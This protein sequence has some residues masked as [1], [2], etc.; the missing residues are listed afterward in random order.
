MQNLI[1][2]DLELLL[3]VLP[4]HLVS[5][6]VNHPQYDELIE[7]IMDLGRPPEARFPEGEVILSERLITNED[8]TYVTDRVGEFGDDNRAGIECTLHRISAIRNRRGTIIGLTCRVGRAVF[9]SVELIRD[10]IEL[11][12]S[13]LIL[14]RPG[15][16]KTTMLRDIARVLADDMDKRVVVVDTS[17]EI[18]GDGDI[19][20]PGIG[21][22]RRMQVAHTAEQHAVMIEAVE[23]HMPQVIV[24]DEIGTELEAQAARTIAERGVQLVGTAHGNTL[25]NLLLN[26]T[27][28]DL[29]GGIGS[30]TL[31]D[32]EARRRGTQKTVLERKSPPTFDV[33]VEQQER[34][35]ILIHL[36]V[37]GTV[38]ALLRGESPTAE[39]RV[40]E[41]TQ[42]RRATCVFDSQRPEL[43][44]RVQSS[45][46]FGS[47]DRRER[48][49]PTPLSAKR[50][51][52]HITTINASSSSPAPSAK[53]VPL[54]SGSSNATALV[55]VE[56]P[57]AI[58]QPRNV[59]GI[60][61]V[62][63]AGLDQS[64]V[65]DVAE[66]FGVKVAFVSS[67]IEADV[68]M[69]HRSRYPRHS[70]LKNKSPDIPMVLLKSRSRD[71]MRT[72][73][74]RI[75][76]LSLPVSEEE[77]MP[78]TASFHP[79][80]RPE[81]MGRKKHGQQSHIKVTHAMQEAEDAIHHI[82]SGYR[83]SIELS[84]QN[85]QIRRIQHQL[86]QRYN[87]RSRSYGEEPNRKVCVFPAS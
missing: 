35:R 30:V 29:V 31:G 8:I 13:L 80:W 50:A 71:N 33:V 3:A 79:A 74:A 56:E 76:G 75:F 28:S 34:N 26:P 42:L 17:N 87:V 40:L 14:G 18:A 59:D 85:S 63:L 83:R 43:A 12:R 19:P 9:G 69:M 44:A 36:D 37:A 72:A 51:E 55:E 53:L 62:F 20:H 82:L 1:T 84:P 77:E 54:A 73:F 11:G 22:A 27:L 46:E 61:R 24:I 4:P 68:F 67:D 66:E 86:A 60:M 23:N 10:V 47:G 45:R 15:V 58:V 5:T 38:D 78:R 32:E 81:D 57:V 21:H 48:Y 39:D 6:L 16:G 64:R 41:D 25:D 2:D 7:V 70:N 65:E 52:R 49:T